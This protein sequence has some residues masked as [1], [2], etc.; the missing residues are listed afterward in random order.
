MPMPGRASR[1]EVTVWAPSRAGSLLQKSKSR[2]QALHHSNGRVSARRKLLILTHRPVGRLS[3]GIDPGVGAKRPFDEVEHIE[4]RCSEANRRRC[5]RIDTGAKEPRALASGP[6]VR[7]Q[8][9]GSFGAFAKGTRCKSETASGNT[10]RNGYSHRTQQPG[11]PRG[12]QGQTLKQHLHQ[13]ESH[14]AA[15]TPDHNQSTAHADHN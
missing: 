10:R 14:H 4:R 2:P 9:F 1:D 13:R 12:R 8:T 7:A 5:A 15:K 3:G 6:N 11:R